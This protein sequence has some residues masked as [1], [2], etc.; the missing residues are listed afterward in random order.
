[1]L[2]RWRNEWT[3][4]TKY[5][6]Q[7]RKQ[8][9]GFITQAISLRLWWTLLPFTNISSSLFFLGTQ[10]FRHGSVSHEMWAE[11]TYAPCRWWHLRSV[12]GLLKQWLWVTSRCGEAA[13]WKPQL[14]LLS[15]QEDICSGE[16][17]ASTEDFGWARNKALW[18]GAKVWQTVSSEDQDGL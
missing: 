3:D 15:Q 7:H 14:G 9:Q 8:L 12:C 17:P 10:E 1:M 18:L 13:R 2:D 4:L 5:K 6:N 11:V 16:L